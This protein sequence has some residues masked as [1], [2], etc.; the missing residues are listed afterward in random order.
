M[1]DMVNG[2]QTGLANALG[3]SKAAVTKCKARG[4]PTHSVDAARSW[5]HEHL[6]PARAKRDPATMYA[7]ELA[8]LESMWPVAAAALTAGSFHV[9]KPALQAAM[10]AVAREARHLVELDAA[11]MVELC[12]WFVQAVHGVGPL[13]QGDRQGPSITSSNDEMCQSE[14]ETMG[15]VWYCVAA[16]EAFPA[17]WLE[18]DRP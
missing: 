13:S 6:D 3:I 18:A 8:A 10:R 7:R 2:R 5:R 15:R 16:G 11:V 14:A 4:M 12:G 1:L 9:I 17:A